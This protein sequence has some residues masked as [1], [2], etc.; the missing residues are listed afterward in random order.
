ML[1]DAEPIRIASWNMTHQRSDEWTRKWDY[2]KTLGVDVA[3]VQEAPKEGPVRILQHSRREYGA[4]STHRCGNAFAV[5][6]PSLNLTDLSS[7]ANG[8]VISA[9]LVGKQP[10]LLVGVHSN[11]N[12]IVGGKGEQ[13]HDAILRCIDSIEKLV[14][15]SKK[16]VLVAGDFN[17]DYHMPSLRKQGHVFR[18]L[19]SLG[20]RDLQ[21]GPSCCVN[22]DGQCLERHDETYSE[23]K[24]KWRSGAKRHRIDH[25]YCDARLRSRVINFSV[26]PDDAW[27]VSDHR[28]IVVQLSH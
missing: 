7:H 22:A 23:L 16:Q 4:A 11:R 24:R 1:D 21:C 5:I 3:L 9:V 6:N 12:N 20:L 15:S 8:D 10:I 26:S 13:Y 28:P 25:M 17:F 2:L 18:R 14:S 19:R 27:D